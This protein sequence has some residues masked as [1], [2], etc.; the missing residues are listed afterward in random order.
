MVMLRTQVKALQRQSIRVVSTWPTYTDT[1]TDRPTVTNGRYITGHTTGPSWTLTGPTWPKEL[2]P[3]VGHTQE[4]T[5]RDQKKEIEKGKK[6]SELR[7][8]VRRSANEG[9]T[10]FKNSNQAR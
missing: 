4:N 2:R 9:H 1:Q 10:Q 5:K 6:K 7:L 3:T 8:T